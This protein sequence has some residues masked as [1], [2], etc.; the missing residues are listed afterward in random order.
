MAFGIGI[1]GTQKTNPIC[2]YFGN[3]LTCLL[4][5]PKFDTNHV[6]LRGGINCNKSDH[7][8][9]PMCTSVITVLQPFESG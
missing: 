2:Y 7:L 3:P 6:P 8:N 9:L 4:V 5:L 1:H